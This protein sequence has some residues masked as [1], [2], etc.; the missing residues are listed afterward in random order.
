MTDCNHEEAIWTVRSQSAGHEI[1]NAL[2]DSLE[3]NPRVENTYALTTPP[4]QFQ[5]DEAGLTVIYP[6]ELLNKRTTETTRTSSR[7]PQKND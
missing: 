6:V 5:I 4:Q 1:R 7:T 2:N 3:G